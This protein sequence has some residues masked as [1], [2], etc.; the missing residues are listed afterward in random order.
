M[1]AAA[2]ETFTLAYLNGKFQQGFLSVSEIPP[3]SSQLGAWLP[4]RLG[5]GDRAKSCLGRPGRRPQ[6]GARTQAAAPGHTRS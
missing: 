3:L 2:P 1:V 6:D 5:S 4:A